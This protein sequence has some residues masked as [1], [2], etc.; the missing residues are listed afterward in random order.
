MKV[1]GT[2]YC[3][4]DTMYIVHGDIICNH[5]PKLVSSFRFVSLLIDLEMLDVDELIPS[6]NNI[7]KIINNGKNKS[8]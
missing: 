8:K 7:S 3:P 4:R 6:V 5:D 2:H 1:T